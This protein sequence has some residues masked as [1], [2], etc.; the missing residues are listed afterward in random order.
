MTI[1]KSEKWWKGT[2]S[3]D[4][5]EYLNSLEPGGYAVDA[6][7]SQSC[8][9]GSTAFKVYRNQ[10]NELSYLVCTA[11]RA[12]TFVTD[13]EDYDLEGGFRTIRCSCKS[14][15]YQVFLGVHSIYEPTIANWMSLGV[16][17]AACGIMGMPLEWEFDTD[18]SEDSYAKHTRPLPGKG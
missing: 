7:L 15:Q 11:C 5:L 2:D 3:A 16:M 10:D 13:S 6:V 8:E 9:C 14:R 1:Q 17:C 12:K 18:K 4:V